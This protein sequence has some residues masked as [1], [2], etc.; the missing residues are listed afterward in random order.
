MGKVFLPIVRFLVPGVFIA[1][2]NNLV[3][4]RYCGS[5]KDSGAKVP[6]RPPPIVFGIVWPIL[7]VTT[8][9]AWAIAKKTHLFPGRSQ[10]LIDSL[11]A[12]IVVL[13]C[14]WLGVYVC[15]KRKKI[16][17]FVLLFTALLSWFSFGVIQHTAGWLMG[18]LAL[19]TSFATVLNMYDAFAIAG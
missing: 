1:I 19:W 8:G 13:C 11:L 6:F 16:A 18:L 4:N 5:L 2:T 12:T 10:L 17:A 9:L 3:V 7:F 15:A 14:V